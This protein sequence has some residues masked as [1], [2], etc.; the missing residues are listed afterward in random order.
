MQMIEKTPDGRRVARRLAGVV[1]AIVA[2]TTGGLIA[3]AAPEVPFLVSAYQAAEKKPTN[4]GINATVTMTTL[5]AASTG[6]KV[7]VAQ[8]PLLMEGDLLGGR[9]PMTFSDA[10]A[11]APGAHSLFFSVSKSGRIG[12]QWLLDDKPLGGAPMQ[13]FDTDVAGGTL[14]KK[15]NW[16]GVYRLVT[17]SIERKLSFRPLPL[18]IFPTP[19]PRPM[20]IIGRVI[21]IKPTPT[22]RPKISREKLDILK[23]RKAKGRKVRVTARFVVTNSD[24]GV[25]G[26]FGNSD[27]SV[28]M[29][30][31]IRLGNQVAFSFKRR[32]AEDGKEIGSKSM[33]SVILTYSDPDYRFFKVAGN[34]YDEDKASASDTMWIASQ[35][36]DLISIMESN[37]EYRIK[38]D[39]NSESADLY[40]RVTDEGEVF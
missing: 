3:R 24:D 12:L 31:S 13:A 32:S 37:T 21:Q 23:R 28:E 26:I 1:A 38:G 16:N 8:G 2:V 14:T 18:R 40:I 20:K 4:P 25:G 10:N 15:L 35:R 19:T 5:G 17:V 30:G 22:P 9:L 29:S 7:L 39:R 6:P 33:E 11:A 36:I 34:I 27:K